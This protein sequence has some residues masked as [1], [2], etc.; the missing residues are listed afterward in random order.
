MAIRFV[1]YLDIYFV[2]K[3]DV[4]HVMNASQKAEKI[5]LIYE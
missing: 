3:R 2:N 4:F 1:Q 5:N